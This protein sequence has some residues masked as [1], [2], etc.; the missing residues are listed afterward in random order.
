MT[1]SLMEEE[2]NRQVREQLNKEKIKLWLPP[3][4]K[5]DGSRGEEHEVTNL[6]ATHCSVRFRMNCQQLVVV[7][8]VDLKK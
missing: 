8:I 1:D 3:Y 2:I 7:G 5:E 4:T 6:Y